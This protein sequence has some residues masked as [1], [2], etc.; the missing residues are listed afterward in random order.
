MTDQEVLAECAWRRCLA[1][2]D[3]DRLGRELEALVSVLREDV[4]Y[5]CFKS[6]ALS[7]HLVA[8]A[9]RPVVG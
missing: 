1:E 3:A 2:A 5:A 6:V 9:Q 8:V 4:R 7:E